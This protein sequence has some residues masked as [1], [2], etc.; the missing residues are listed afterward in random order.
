M[1]GRQARQAEA[2]DVTKKLSWERNP[3]D[4]GFIMVQI[5]TGFFSCCSAHLVY[6]SLCSSTD[7]S[8][9]SCQLHT[10]VQTFPQGN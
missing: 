10:E 6:V 7:A 3:A 9:K 1:L 5:H 8:F 4:Q 2:E